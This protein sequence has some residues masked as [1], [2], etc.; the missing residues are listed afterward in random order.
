MT[1][2]FGFTYIHCNDLL[3][4]K[5]FYG[6]ILNLEKIW[7]DAQSVAFRIG[8]HQLTIS[9]DEGLALP[10]A[11]FS[12]QPGWSGGTAVRTS[13]SLECGVTDFRQIV[14]AAKAAGVKSWQQELAW[15][16]Y[17]SYPLLD[18]MNNTIEV[19]CPEL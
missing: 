11:E 3:A 7:E 14:A 5:H 2:R 19:T 12:V 1:R 17:W 13:W 18:P 16:G 10:P 9:L 6:Q 15:V 8:D 4:M